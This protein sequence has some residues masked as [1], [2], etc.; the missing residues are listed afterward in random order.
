MAG[1]TRRLQWIRT[2]LYHVKCKARA[3]LRF[4]S[5]LL[6]ALVSRV[7]LREKRQP[8]TATVRVDSAQ[9]QYRRLQNRLLV[10]TRATVAAASRVTIGGALLWL[11]A[12]PGPS[13]LRIAGAFGS[14][15]R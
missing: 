7:N 13:V 15:F 4:S 3:A 10:P 2:K 9:R 5:F 8:A 6:N 12:R 11:G 14:D 1:V